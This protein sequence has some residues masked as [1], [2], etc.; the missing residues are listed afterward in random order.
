MKIR[1][2]QK[3]VKNAF[4]LKLL[5]IM[6]NMCLGLEFGMLGI[7]YPRLCTDK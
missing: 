4:Q 5:K 7:W 6:F 3:I 1:I 2:Q